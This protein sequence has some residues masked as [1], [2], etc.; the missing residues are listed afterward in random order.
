MSISELNTTIQ[1]SCITVLAL[2]GFLLTK[3]A[4]SGLNSWTGVGFIAAIICYLLIET[5]F[6]EGNKLL[7]YIFLTGATS[8]PVFFLLLSKAI[9]EDRFKVSYH[10]VFWFLIQILPHFPIYLRDHISFD[11]DL[12]QFLLIISEI[13]SIGFVLAGIYTAMKTKQADLV[14]SRLRFRSTFVII[15][16]ALIGVTLIVESTPLARESTVTLQLLQRTSILALTGYFVVNNFQIKAGF[17]FKEVPKERPVI[18]PV[19]KTLRL[20]LEDLLTNMKIYRKEGLTIRELADTMNEQ[21]YRVR[22]LINVELG[23]RNFNDFLN[24]CRVAEACEILTDPSKNRKTI[25]EIAY[26][27]GYQSI[28]PFNRAFK[29]LKNTTPTAYR[30][31]S[32]S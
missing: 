11:S 1:I 26:D 3:H 6:V 13:T 7:W 5:D 10:V 21:E 30:K 15:T 28:G 20:K 31:S 18:P 29:D 24:Q 23:F 2:V 27:L 17:F 4:K 12:R 32:Q 8:I 25:L 22:R 19:D 16:A 9:F 14:E